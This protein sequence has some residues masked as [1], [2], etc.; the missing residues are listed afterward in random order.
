MACTIVLTDVKGVTIAGKLD[1]I[2]VFGTATNC[3]LVEVTIECS[4]R[5]TV[6]AKVQDGAWVASFPAVETG[7]ACGSIITVSAECVSGQCRVPPTKYTLFCEEQTNCPLVTAKAPKISD[8]N[9]DGT[10]TVSFFYQF[11]SQGTP[12]GAKLL[13][14]GVVEDS[15]P[16]SP[17]PAATFVLTY[18][19]TLPP[20]THSV[21][22]VFD[23]VACGGN[24]TTFEVD[25]CPLPGDCPKITFEEPRFESDCRDGS[26]SVRVVATVEPQG[27]PVNANLVGAGGTVLASATGQITKFTLSGVQNL[28]NGTTTISVVVTAPNGCPGSTQQVQVD[29]P[30]APR[31]SG[32]PSSGGSDDDDGGGGGCFFGRVL[33]VM[34]FATALFLFII[35]ICLA[36]PYLLI[37]AAVAAVVAGIAFALW[38]AF[39]GSK[40]AALLLMWQV[41]AIGA[42]V[43]AFL[44]LCC[45]WVIFVAIG[46][47]LAALA[48]FFG[49]IQA[50]RP[51]AC[52]VLFELLWL[53][54]TPVPFIL[55]PLS[56]IAPCGDPGVPVW[57]GLAAAA[58][59]LAWGAGCAK[60]V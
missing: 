5:K 37:A 32:G 42:A 25:P 44:V 13:V 19:T 59:A 51:S 54:V 57:I 33:I 36:L 6:G 28:P 18:S 38:W 24:T 4:M 8:C 60:K 53:F 50:C 23:P 7:C 45:P 29:C 55:K 15:V 26:R 40:C 10:R 58:L 1:H 27:A 43:A 2:F 17:P 9:K 56:A 35:G 30:S 48:G 11:V 22:Y 46:L 3:D 16:A 41:A 49:W 34:L 20:G 14:D 47:G 21:A 52:K 12:V 39:C 31:P